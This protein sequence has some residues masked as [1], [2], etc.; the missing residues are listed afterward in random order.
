MYCLKLKLL[1]Y[2]FYIII[3]KFCKIQEWYLYEKYITN[4]A[5]NVRTFR[6]LMGWSYGKILYL[7]KMKLFCYKVKSMQH[8]W[9]SKFPSRAKTNPITMKIFLFPFI[10]TRN[11]SHIFKISCYIFYYWNSSLSK[12]TSITQNSLF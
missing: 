1:L 4:W 2:K 9:N 11:F 7:V 10:K 5:I 8:I 6:L 3:V 12:I